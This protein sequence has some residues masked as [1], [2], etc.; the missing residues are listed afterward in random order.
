MDGVFITI[1]PGARRAAIV[2][3]H[4]TGRLSGRPLCARSQAL[5][6]APCALWMGVCGGCQRR[7]AD[8]ADVLARWTRAALVQLYTG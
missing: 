7:H 2:Q 8:P 5:N 3:M 4:R 1:H 6:G